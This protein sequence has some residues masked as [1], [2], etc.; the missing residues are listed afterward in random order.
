MTVSAPDATQWSTL[1]VGNIPGETSR[2][3]LEHFFSDIGPVKK[4][5]TVK[6]REG[7]TSTIGFVTF[8]M[9]EDC[10]SALNMENPELEGVKLSL[11]MAPD[12]KIYGDK[13][14]GGGP[15]V[16]EPST[17]IS[18]NKAR[19]VI[20]NLSFKADDDSLKEHFAKFGPV[21]DV[22]ILKKGDG[23][24]VGCAFVEFKKIEFA[25]A[26]IK[27]ANGSKFLNRPIAVDWAV[28]KEVFASK[29]EEEVKDEVKDEEIKDEEIKEE[30]E[31]SEGEKMDQDG[32]EDEDVKEEEDDDSE[33]EEE[34]IDEGQEE[35]E[36]DEDVTQA[37]PA[38]NLKMGHDINEGKTVFIRNISYDSAEEDLSAMMEECFGPIVF[39]KL[40]WDKAMGHPRG[41]GFVKFKKR[42]DAVKCVEVA[43]GKDGV[44]LDN[45]QLNILMAKEK[46]D[47]EAIQKERKEKEP[48]D[49]RNLYLA[50]EGIIREGTAAAEGVSKSDMDRRK[51]VQKQKKQMLSNL[52]MFVS[53]TRICVRN[54]PPYIDDAKLRSIFA[55]NVPK[56]AKIVEAKVMKDNKN[57]DK[58]KQIS[59]GFG[60][61]G[62]SEH[63]DALLALRNTNNN[64]TIF[65]NDRRPIV[66]F[67]IENRQALLARQKRL[68]KSREKNPNSKKN[69]NKKLETVNKQRDVSVDK[70]TFSGMT[71]DPKQKGLPTHSGPKV[72][73]GKNKISRKDL[74]QKELERK[75]PKLRKK[76]EAKMA[77]MPNEAK[78]PKQLKKEMRKQKKLSREA[79]KEKESE[80]KFSGLVN[81]YVKNIQ[82]NQTVVKKWFDS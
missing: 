22:N 76:R 30:V 57:E 77:V 56:S 8:A 12:R 53:S 16:Q 51:V 3:Q 71:S 10:K 9:A 37:P 74:K 78:A 39:A 80:K 14:K 24:M 81:Q 40:V 50:R 64:P 11:K 31:D 1:Q 4:C 79:Q 43:E 36:Y 18:K 75:N 41:T 48:K 72:R 20:R 60:F 45:R 49:N 65:T 25:N 29:K 66:E 19:L 61:V 2:Y 6:P 27:G 62:F 21:V 33:D 42:E 73:T 69:D 23:K 34:D 28:P 5:F 52:N 63:E 7:K 46:G 32:S 26:A 59:K 55:K 44:F 17:K 13:K 47:V 58:A 35:E 68:E 54:L 67:A 15:G 82:S 70:S 38:H